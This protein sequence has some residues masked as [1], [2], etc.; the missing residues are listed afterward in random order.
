MVT[1]VVAGLLAGIVTSISPCVLPVLPVV[2]TSAGTRKPY[3]IV[4][5]LVL[6]FGLT[7]LFG[8]ILLN[9]LNLPN[10]LLRTAG[11]VVLV[12]LSLVRQQPFGL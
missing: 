8:A 2:L 5:G 10:A 12:L 4:A 9:S 3:R 6:S 7:T 1:L 11:I